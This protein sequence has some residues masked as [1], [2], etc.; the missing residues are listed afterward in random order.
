MGVRTFD[1]CIFKI[2]L[3]FF[4]FHDSFS[5]SCKRDNLDNFLV[6]KSKIHGICGFFFSK[7]DQVFETRGYEYILEILF[8]FVTEN[9]CRKCVLKI[10]R[11]LNPCELIRE[12]KDWI[13]LKENCF[14]VAKWWKMT[15][16]LRFLK[17][18]NQCNRSKNSSRLLFLSH[19]HAIVKFFFQHSFIHFFLFYYR[20]IT[21]LPKTTIESCDW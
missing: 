6:R 20:S 15:N 16:A 18:V 11:R 3:I 12:K 17:F 8:A 10:I 7:I 4:L 14:V 13:F 19:P 2:L 21:F 5:R 1:T 9:I